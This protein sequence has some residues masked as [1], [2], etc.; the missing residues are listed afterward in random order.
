MWIRCRMKIAVKY[1]LVTLLGLW[2]S[3][4][5][6]HAQEPADLKKQLQALTGAEKV[7]QY[8]KIGILFSEK[9]G[10]SDSLLFYSQEA[11]R[12]SKSIHYE[13]G[14]WSAELNSGI[15]FQQ[16]NKFDTAVSVLEELLEKVKKDS[17]SKLLGDV[18]YYLGLSQYRAGNNK[19]A[20]EHFINAV[21]NYEKLKDN[22]GLVLA[23][24]KLAGVL[25]NEKQKE[26]SLEYKN[27]ARNLLPSMD[28][29]YSTISS[30][31]ALSGI[32]IQ[33]ND[34]SPTYTDSSIYYAK[35]ALRLMN[36]F[37]YYTKAN[38]ISNSI[39]DAYYMKQDYQKALEYC[40]E[41][42][43]YR[44]YLFPG[45]IIIS[46]L[47]YTDCANALGDHKKSLL[48][49][50]SVKYALQSIDDQF[51]EMIYYERVYEY[52]KAA[53]NLSEALV[54][55][56]KFKSIQDSMFNAEKSATINEL[57]QKYNKSE[58]E[59]KISELNKENEIASLNVKFL[60]IGIISTILVIV[61][62]V[63]LFRQSTLKSRFKILETEQRLNRARMN[64][65]FFFNA[66]SSI[67]SLSEDENTA[68][69]VPR[70]ISKFSKIMRQSL[71]STYDELVTLE[72]EI[73]FIQNYLELQKTRYPGK[74][75]YSVELG[76]DIDVSD[77][78]MPSMLLQP[79]IENAIE[80]GF[81]NISYRGL[82]SI[83][84]QLENNQLKVVSKDNGVGLKSETTPKAF[85]SR[86][87]Q[88]IQ[89]RL[90]LLNKKHE[91][92]AHFKL[93]TPDVGGLEVVVYLPV[94]K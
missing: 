72:S 73:D 28:D 87:S 85:P 66:L 94:I 58:N 9:Y 61:V 44:K 11:G 37:G 38:Q 4:A 41:S 6:L 2:W 86:A 34:K 90:V 23:Y 59:K 84:F 63:F 79:F 35:E 5:C 56:E 91:S 8:L 51:Y 19:S 39:S 80:H 74:F 93:L 33:L 55:L 16:M 14:S 46:Y 62:I 89:E 71:E 82:L 26:E 50:D 68:K 3:I 42:L 40:I 36:E 48:Y 43:K 92:N 81:K 24:C 69:D 29:P 53:G 1:L 57:I 21:I 15:A 31:S 76:D 13:V 47:K 18:Y 70:M 45:E 54:G 88:I 49:L 60:I 12:L 7:D 17:K 10:Q 25:I 52:N 22:N 20:T 75:D 83:N 65:H 78:K 67:Q 27:K 64:P 32:Y 30:Y 77:L